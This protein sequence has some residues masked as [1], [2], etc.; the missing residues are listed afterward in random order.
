MIKQKQP[1]LYTNIG[2]KQYKLYYWMKNET[3]KENLISEKY[4]DPLEFSE[5]EKT[6][7]K[8]HDNKYSLLKPVCPQ[9]KSIKYT[10]HGYNE[11]IIIEKGIKPFKIRLQRYKCK[12]CESYYQTKMNKTLNPESTYN[13]EIKDY[14][15]VINTLQHVSLRNIAKIIEFEWN[16]RPSPQSIKNW[17]K[18]TSIK[19]KKEHETCYS[20]YYN[21][22]EQYVKIKG[23]WM[24][25]LA[26]FDI[27]NNILVKEKISIKLNSFVVKSFLKEIKGKIPI[28]AITTDHKPYYRKILDDLKIKHQLCIFHFKKEINTRIKKIK[29]KNNINASEIKQII[30][31]KNLMFEIVDSKDY[32]SAVQS[33]TKLLIKIND[34]PP[35]FKKFIFKKFVPNFKR[36][37][38]FLKDENITKTS[39]KIEN[40]FRTTLPKSIKKIFKT[41]KGLKE[42]LTLQNKKWEIKRKIKNSN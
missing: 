26:L 2:V 35:F 40:Y 11:K 5:N 20:G 8:D 12:K 10:K 30:S 18:E 17:L 21:Y 22:D 23:K 31:N 38:N 7:S 42:Y 1:A 16:K 27:Q 36:Y 13:N 4:P 33:F 15:K 28:I 29:R 9:C 25:R 41:I 39:N 14:P 6:V 32:Q 19:D 24:Y 37:L 34:N 3:K